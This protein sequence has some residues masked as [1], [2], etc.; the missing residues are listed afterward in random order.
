MR[1]LNSARKTTR[2]SFMPR[3]FD[4]P[5]RQSYLMGMLF[6]FRLNLTDFAAISVSMP[7]PSDL[8]AMSFIAD[9]FRARKPL[10]LLP[11]V[12]YNK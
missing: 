7:K 6:V 10:M 1:Y 4:A 12:R 11:F 3:N 8:S 9:F 5:L 2:L